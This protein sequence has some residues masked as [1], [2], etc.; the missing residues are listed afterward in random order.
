MAVMEDVVG[1]VGRAVDVEVVAQDHVQVH[2]VAVPDV[3]MVVEVAV[4]D[5]LVRVLEDVVAAQV[6]LEGAL[7][8]PVVLEGAL[9]VPVV[10][11]D[12]TAVQVGVQ[13]VP[14]LVQM[15]V[16]GVPAR[17]QVT[18]RTVMDV[19]AVLTLVQGHASEDVLDV[20]DVLA[21]AM[22]APVNAMDVAIVLVL[23]AGVLGPARVV[24]DVLQ[25]VQPDAEVLAR[26]HVPLHVTQHAAHN[27]GEHV[28]A[29]QLHKLLTN[30]C[31]M[32]YT[33]SRD[34][35]GYCIQYILHINMSR[36]LHHQ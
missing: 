16:S 17:A 7:D 36:H 8:V 22:G 31:N 24:Q 14:V 25:T 29:H 18:A 13:V 28:L 15:D 5:V 23:V 6:V 4:R 27:V 30:V 26:L 2:V 1:L 21:L 20:L 19:P 12:V 33:V 11:E 10:L 32:I 3:E 35:A 34:I 9:G